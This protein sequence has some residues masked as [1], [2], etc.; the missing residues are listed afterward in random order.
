[1]TA[2]LAGEAPG[3]RLVQEAFAAPHDL[4]ERALVLEGCAVQFDR[5]LRLSTLEAAAPPRLR[6]ILR[7]ATACAVRQAL[8]VPCQIAE[9]AEVAGDRGMRVM[10]LKGAAQLL[11]GRAP[12]ARSMSD[13]DVIASPGEARQLH[14]ILRERL[15]YGSLSASPEHHLPT[16]TRPGALPVEVHIQLGPRRTPLDSRIWLDAQNVGG[17]DLVVP[18]PTSAL[19]HALEHG[20]LVH[21]AVRY[22]LRDLL[23]VAHAWE[24]GI[25]GNEVG[26]YLRSHPQ[27]RALTTLLGGARRFSSAIPIGRRS[28]WRTVRRIARV[29][30]LVAAHVR[31]AARA[32]SLCIAAGVLAEGSPRAVLRPAELALFGVRQA[33]VG[34]TA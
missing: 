26:E 2:V 32:K 7:A 33:R 17:T 13:I 16:L 12:G 31:D 5:A 27:R 1:M 11:G 25:D 4:W 21:W 20:A 6:Q 3:S 29:R 24:P 34:A 18:S 30:H 10:V 19:L 28:A 9:L 15:G 8:T 22:R 23:D 14:T